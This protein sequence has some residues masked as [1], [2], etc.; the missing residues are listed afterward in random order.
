MMRYLYLSG[1]LVT[2]LS[3]TEQF[4]KQW[5]EDSGPDSQDVMQAQRH[6][7]N[8]LRLLGRYQES[9]D[10]TRKILTASTRILGEQNPL[11][12]SLRASFS[13][14]LRARGEFPV[15]RDHDE[16]TRA[17]M[18][19]AYGL[20]DPQIL[21]L[22]ASLALDY[23]LNSAYT[24][25]RDLYQ[26]VFQQ[27][28]LPSLDVPSNDV[29]GAWTG[30]A[31]A[32]RMCGTYDEARD[33]G[34]FAWVYA[35]DRL[36]AEHQ[37]TLRSLNAM[38]IASRRIPPA[39]EEALAE[40]RNSLKMATRLF[41]AQNPDT[42]ATAINLANL[43]RTTGNL[44]EAL[45]LA[46]KTVG[47]YPEAY[48]PEHPYN[49]GCMGNL[50]ML[51]RVTGDAAGARK[52]DEEALAGLDGRLGRDH[53]YTLTVAV[54]LASDLADLGLATDAR[55]LGEGTLRRMQA[56]LGEDHPASLG[57]AVNLAVDRR[58]TGDTDVAESLMAETMRR[59]ATKLGLGHPD[60]VVAAEWRRL[61]LDF[62][63]P[64]I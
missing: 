1:D 36:G 59:Y 40:T 12:L 25:A 18:E 42:L 44:D 23:G 3:L 13:A 64:P 60:A 27:M 29:V 53:H 41:G 54:N 21:R 9:S 49:Y 8:A 38:T 61:D 10:L 19:V 43:L 30:L 50:A 32:V 4:I 57:C 48:G 15:A 20:D 46:E 39:R 2:C 52:L 55:A 34:Q 63:P 35:R 22:Q 37:S 45:E 24:R 31:W 16:E 51:R 6:R 47:E 5:S 28:S 58:A 11:T 26:S 62:D 7:G 33:V 17:L 14:D 56:V